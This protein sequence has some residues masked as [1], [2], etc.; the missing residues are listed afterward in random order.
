MKPL[1]INLKSYTHC[2]STTSSFLTT[3]RYATAAPAAAEEDPETQHRESSPSLVEPSASNR[4][5][6]LERLR[7][8]E[9]LYWIPAHWVTTIYKDLLGA[10]KAASPQDALLL[11]QCFDVRLAEE[12]PE[13]RVKMAEK[14]WQVS[15][16]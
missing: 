11:L 15:E 13:N 2:A 3:R 1:S 16:C 7:G 12:T 5:S 4:Q 10:K 14:A 9:T 6:Y 8:G